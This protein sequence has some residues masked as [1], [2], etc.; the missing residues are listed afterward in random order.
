LLS[1]S[2]EVPAVSG[3]AGPLLQ[4]EGV[5]LLQK[6]TR[7]R[8]DPQPPARVAEDREDL[9]ERQIAEAAEPPEPAL[10]ALVEIILR[11]EP[12]TAAAVEERGVETRAVRQML[13]GG[14][15]LADDVA[16]NA[17]RIAVGGHDPGGAVAARPDRV[18]VG[19]ALEGV[20]GGDAHDPR[21]VVPPH[22]AE[23]GDP[24]EAVGALVD[25]TNPAAGQ[26]VAHAPHVDG[27][28]GQRLRRIQRACRPGGGRDQARDEDEAKDAERSHLPSF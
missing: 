8:A 14:Q 19:D 26:P 1:N 25:V 22:T 23:G 9:V 4:H 2:D 17:R 5:P 21:A 15:A 11:G 6:E 18:C 13:A 16:A 24:E 27:A 7:A 28:L 3:P 20:R 10:V 12:R